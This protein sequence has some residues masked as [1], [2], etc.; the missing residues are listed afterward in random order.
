MSLLSSFIINSLVHRHF[1]S[2]PFSLSFPAH[3]MPYSTCIILSL[4]PFLL[5]SGYI[6]NISFCINSYHSSLFTC[7]SL[8]INFLL[9][10]LYISFPYKLVHYLLKVLFSV[11]TISHF[12]II[13]YLYLLWFCMYYFVLFRILYLLFCIIILYLFFCVQY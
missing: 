10:S 12:F 11:S 9:L 8:Y 4:F 5:L 1:L 7:L 6:P 2:F 3:I 13:Y